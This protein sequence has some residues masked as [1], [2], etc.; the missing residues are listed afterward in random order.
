M[1]IPIITSILTINVYTLHEMTNIIPD[2][3]F[4]VSEIVNVAIILFVI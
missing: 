4:V 3:I 1:L 2:S